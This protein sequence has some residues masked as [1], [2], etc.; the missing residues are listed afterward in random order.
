M[1]VHS[2]NELTFSVSEAY[3]LVGWCVR[4]SKTAYFASNVAATSLFMRTS[5]RSNS[6]LHTWKEK[7]E[8]KARREKNTGEIKEGRK[9]THG[10]TLKDRQTGLTNGSYSIFDIGLP[11]QTHLPEIK[12]LDVTIVIPSS[13][14]PLFIIEWVSCQQVY[15]LPSAMTSSTC[16]QTHAHLTLSLIQ[17]LCVHGRAIGLA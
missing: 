2:V 7:E 10:V 4:R 11:P 16:T 17:C 8:K 5:F 3:P 1:V 15:S 13:H 12:Q 6:R 14:T 9:N